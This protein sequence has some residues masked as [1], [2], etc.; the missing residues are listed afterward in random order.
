MRIYW[1]E[2]KEKKDVQ[3]FN[4]KKLWNNEKKDP[5]YK[6]YI[7]SP[8]ASIFQFHYYGNSPSANLLLMSSIHLGNAVISSIT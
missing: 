5:T 7:T 3:K 4:E 2:S 1:E 6:N 8:V